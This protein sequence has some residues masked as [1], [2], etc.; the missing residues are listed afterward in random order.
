MTADFKK[1]AQRGRV[2]QM[3]GMALLQV[4]LCQNA[5]AVLFFSDQFNYTDAANL[6]ASGPWAPG[7]SGIGNN[8]AEIKVAS[9][10]AQT[11][12]GGYASAA[13]RGVAVTPTTT[14]R[15]TGALFNDSTG[16][17]N[18]DGNA[19]Y[20]SFLLNVQDFPTSNT[21]VAYLHDATSSAAAV[22]VWINSAGQIGAR[23]KSGSPVF[24]TTITTNATHL[25]VVRYSFQLGNDPVALWVNPGSDNYGVEPPPLPNTTITNVASDNGSGGIK[26]F[27]I[28]S[29][30]V[31]DSAY[32]IDEVRVGTTW[33][34]VTPPGPIPAPVITESLLAPEGMIL[35]G[36]NGPS[37]GTYQV[38]RSTNLTLPLSHWP[39]IAAH[40]FDV[41]GN[42]DSTNP[43]A[44][45]RTHEFFRLLVGTIPSATPPNF[46]T[47]LQ[48]L[49]VEPGMTARF[50]VGVSGTPPFA[51][52]WLFNTSTPIGG[53][54]NS[55]TVPNVQAGNAGAY[56]VVVSNNFGAVTS[57]VATLA[58]NAPVGFGQGT[59]GGAGG[60]VVTVSNV[61]DLFAYATSS[62]P[63]IIS[64]A[65]NI[66]I[67]NGEGRSGGALYIRS[68][69]TIQGVDTNATITGTLDLGFGGVTNVIIRNL[70]I[71]N[72]NDIG[73]GDGITVFGAKHVWVTHCNIFDCADGSCDINN[74]ADY[75]TVSWCKLYY[76]DPG[77]EHRYT[78][79]SG[80]T[81]EPDPNVQ[82]IT[83]HH[84]WWAENCDQ[85]MPSGSFN[86]VHMFNN[87]FSCSG[88]SYCSNGRE[89]SQMLSENNYYHAVKSPIYKESGG[90]MQISGNIYLNCTGT[91][92]D[93]GNDTV[94]APAYSYTVDTT[95]NVP[96]T[97][98]ARAGNNGV[99]GQ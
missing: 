82:R 95:S 74:S 22:E 36:S 94:F 55:L 48:S 96:A 64:I 87:Y 16:V 92:P 60:A 32:W 99:G 31:A 63:C 10:A 7:T 61:A 45:S 8:A 20:A 26:Y 37:G 15:V 86:K 2:L 80:N 69:K 30:N 12:P 41:T 9:A 56:R 35:R 83:L 4:L 67:T 25:V 28:E 78:M 1:S 98:M 81:T 71:T 44:P 33:A 21:R 29:P 65:G 46:T 79:I 66:T 73:R 24:A 62:A 59:T 50:F 18:T 77:A 34:D 89:G 68:N 52:S 42:F 76:T 90:L 88:N 17:S 84:N 97:V 13:F 14:A 3:F 6:G 49:I 11:S 70:N 40:T 58:I 23:K 85:R 75:I 72:P 27:I 43:V 47:Q 5:P 38:V 19:V 93:A 39:S 91:A 54:S 51:Y 53:N 57:T